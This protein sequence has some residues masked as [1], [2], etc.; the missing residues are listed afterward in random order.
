[1]LARVRSLFSGSYAAQ[2]APIDISEVLTKACEEL[3]SRDDH[4]RAR[5]AEK[6]LKAQAWNVDLSYFAFDIISLLGSP[7]LQVRYIGFRACWQFLDRHSPAVDMLPSVIRRSVQNEM[8]MIPALHVLTLVINPFIFQ[9]LETDLIEIARTSTDIA[10][11]LVIHSLFLVYKQRPSVLKC[12]API[13]SRSVFQTSLR[14]TTLAILTEIA[15]D[16]PESLRQFIPLLIKELPL[17]TPLAFMKLAKFF[18]KMLTVDSSLQSELEKV[19]PHYLANHTDALSIIEAGNLVASFRNTTNSLLVSQIASQ[20]EAHVTY[21]DNPNVKFLCLRVLSRLY[22]VYKPEHGTVSTATQCVDPSVVG[23]ALILKYQMIS[24][25][26]ESAEEIIRHVE[27]Y[28]DLELATTLL[29]LIPRKGDRFIRI[30]FTLYALGLPGLH[31]VLG[32]VVRSIIDVDTQQR[33]V[34]EVAKLSETPDDEFGFSLALAIAEW[35]T[36]PDDLDV[37]IPSSIGQKAEQSQ[38]ELL[39]CAFIFWS[40]LSFDV[41]KTLV[42]RIELLAC[43]PVRDVRQRAAELASLVKLVK[44]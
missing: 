42:N 29:Y 19:L 21:D 41:P 15:N 14:F 35:S 23:Q 37:I 43:S 6:L 39:T 2:P 13:L 31:R 18:S 1:M 3:K 33:L 34:R 10:R 24:K 4:T 36:D 26:I 28:R 17:S 8:L 25:K 12:L 11:R 9:S 20:I 40:R 32:A 22:P 7:D 16:D 44:I 5:G 30:L 27:Q 38:A